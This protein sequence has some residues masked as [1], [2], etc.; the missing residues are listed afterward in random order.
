MISFLMSTA[1]LLAA[2][3][4]A[5]KQAAPQLQRQAKITCTT[6]KQKALA[7]VGGKSLRVVSAELEKEGGRLV[8]SFDVARRGHSGVEEI[9]IDARNGEIVSAKHETAKDE[10]NERY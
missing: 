9:Q 2:G 1:L 4:G 8:Y 5:C 6:A 3:S 10:A 7:S